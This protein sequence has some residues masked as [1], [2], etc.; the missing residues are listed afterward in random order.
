MKKID[1][2]EGLILSLVTRQCGPQITS[3]ILT[4]SVFY[5]RELAD[6]FLQIPEQSAQPEEEIENVILH[7]TN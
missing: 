5:R 4:N 1:F 6:A 7:G 2:A 3:F